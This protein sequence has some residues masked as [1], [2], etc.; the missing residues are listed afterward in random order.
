MHSGLLLL[1]IV[2]GP[3]SVLPGFLG[4]APGVLLGPLLV[5][6]PGSCSVNQGQKRPRQ[7]VVKTARVRVVGQSALGCGRQRTKSPSDW[8]QPGAFPPHAQGIQGGH[9]GRPVGGYGGGDGHEPPGRRR[10][11]Q[12]QVGAYDAFADDGVVQVPFE[13]RKPAS[14]CHGPMSEDPL[15]LDLM[16][17]DPLSLDPWSSGKVS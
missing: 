12:A 1:R 10:D 17:L 14:R 2:S 5:P 13:S 11:A 16:S 8:V 7:V 3:V 4:L 6:R 15:S 9:P